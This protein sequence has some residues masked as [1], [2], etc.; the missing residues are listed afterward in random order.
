MGTRRFLV[1]HYTAGATALSSW[2][3]WKSGN[4]GGAEA[5][6]LIDRD[7]TV[8]QVRPFNQKADHAGKSAWHD[9]GDG[10]RYE[11]LNACSIGI[12]LANAGADDP[13]KPDAFDW[14]KRQ[15]GFSSIKAAHKNG[16]PVREWEAY[17]PEQLAACEAVSRALVT[18]YDLD[19]VIGHEDIAPDRKPDPGPAFPMA[20]L[21][22][23]CGFT[24]PIP[25]LSHP[26][27]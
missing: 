21:R 19:D 17:T 10:K 15:P 7:G 27:K 11:W 24:A 14:A 8:Y 13:A 20:R 18:R 1:I 25:K 23:A 6:L 22:A 26:L 9:P 12:E 16:G 4:A 5:H 2:E 3:H